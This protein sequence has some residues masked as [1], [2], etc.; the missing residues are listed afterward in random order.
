MTD[1]PILFTGPMVRA[2]LEGRKTQ[3]RRVLKPQPVG[4]CS[5][6]E[7][8]RGDGGGWIAG[9]NRAEM[10]KV[11]YTPGDRLYV[12][13]AC[14]IVGTCDPGWVLYRAN[15]YEAECHRHGFDR[16]PDESEISWKP[17]I[18]MPRWAS[19]L[20]LTVT[21]VRVQRV[22]EIALEDV[23]A[24]GIF[25]P[26]DTTKD[27]L[28]RAGADR[29]AFRD[30]WDSINAKR[31]FGWADNPWVVALTFQTHHCNIDQMEAA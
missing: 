16:F 3:T 23:Y 22:Q 13:E 28:Q 15:G 12:R 18:H 25:T 10:V 11:P 14:A 17:S 19:R 1:R 26:I 27:P 21:D 30:L 9:N 4:P 7:P 5:H 2:I 31:G 6:I 29:T 20:T 24:E 8:F